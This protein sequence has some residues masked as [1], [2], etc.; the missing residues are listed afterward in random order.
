MKFDINKISISKLVPIMILILLP[1]SWYVAIKY[2]VHL[3]DMILMHPDL[4]EAKLGII[5]RTKL[6][7]PLAELITF[8]TVVIP[9]IMVRKAIREGTANMGHDDSKKD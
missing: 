3:T 5:E 6:E 9:A 2:N 8:A 7:L 1:L 4:S